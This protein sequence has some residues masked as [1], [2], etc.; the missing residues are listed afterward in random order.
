[1]RL[2]NYLGA[3][4]AIASMASSVSAIPA[5]INYQGKLT[6]NA[7]VPVADG[8]YQMRFYLYDSLNGNTLLWQEP[9]QGNP[10]MNVQVTGGV[11]TVALGN[12]VALPQSAFEGNTYLLTQVNGVNQSPRVRIVSVGYAFRAGTVDSPLTLSDAVNTGIVI[13]GG[14]PSAV[15]KGDNTSTTASFP[16][17]PGV[18][19]VGENGA[20]NWGYLGGSVGVMGKHFDTEN[21]GYLGTESYGAYGENEGSDNF[22]YLG[23]VSY[24]AYGK[25]FSSGNYGF[26]GSTS[27]GA[28]GAD[29]GTGAYGYLGYGNYGVYASDGSTGTH[30]G[31]FAGNVNVTGRLTV[32]DKSGASIAFAAGT[33]DST[34]SL[35]DGVNV[36]SVTWYAPNQWYEI[37]CG[38]VNLDG[39]AAIVTPQAANSARM[40][41]TY[42]TNGL[43]IVQIYNTAGTRIQS[44]FA[45]V[46]YKL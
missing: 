25:H 41:T 8:S 19:V 18:G 34:G 10:S 3:V 22:G 21:F 23:S 11:F 40:A 26:L 12:T 1:M 7:G 17:V 38:G 37:S 39:Y 4:A 46:V 35:K 33:V 42:S 14:P 45:F 2:I 43:L 36:S 24:G 28:Y 5:I 44:D 15:F 16:F 30:A 32:G 31:Y 27:A 29:G 6:N 20:G 9:A 13:S